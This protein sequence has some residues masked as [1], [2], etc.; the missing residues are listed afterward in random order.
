MKS[1]LIE[2]RKG[3][4]LVAGLAVAVVLLLVACGGSATSAPAAIPAATATLAPVPTLAPTSTRAPTATTPPEATTTP[5]PSPTQVPL[6]TPTQQTVA[7]L[8]PSPEPTSIGVP[9]TEEPQLQGGASP[10]TLGPSKDNT[11]YQASSSFT[12]NGSGQHLFVGNTG[13]GSA[14]RALLAFDVGG[15][16]PEGATINS[17]TLRLNMSRTQADVQ[18]IGLHRLLANWGEGASDAGGQ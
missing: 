1:F 6:P 16:I 9:L 3:T 18:E 5:A 8:E 12:S 14:R 7:T 4:G 15:A 17:V 10:V 2:T 13:T 11:L